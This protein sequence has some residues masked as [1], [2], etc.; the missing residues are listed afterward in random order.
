MIRHMLFATTSMAAR[1]ERAEADTSRANSPSG[2]A[3]AVRAS[4]SSRS[5]ARHA[6]FGGPGN[7][8]T[9]SAGLG[10]A[11]VERRDFEAL[12][13]LYDA[14]DRGDP[15]RAID[16]RRSCRRGAAHARGYELIGYENVLGLALDAARVGLASRACRKISRVAYGYLARRSDRDAAVDR[17]RRPTA[18]CIPTHF[19]GPPPTETFPRDAIEGVFADIGSASRNVALYLARRDGEIAGGGSLRVSAGLAQLAGAA[20]L[21]AHRRRGVQS[22]LLRSQ[23]A[24]CGRQRLR[25]RRRHHR[26]GLEVAAERPA[27]RI[28][29]AL[30]ASGAVVRRAWR[31]GPSSAARPPD[32]SGIREVVVAVARERAGG[33]AGDAGQNLRGPC[34]SAAT[35]RA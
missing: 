4:S 5:A 29:A 6:V 2:R 9:S 27:R 31:R 35:D 20:T 10:F 33:G 26:A 3:P 15:R 17:N 8:S 16:A 14:R 7:R 24:R 21:P 19:D 13:A 1:I 22:A 23:A 25:P 12:E 18:S 28:R 32:G 30:L 34:A 11:P